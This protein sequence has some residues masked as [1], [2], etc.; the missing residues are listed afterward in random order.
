MNL[1]TRVEQVVSRYEGSQISN[2][3]IT[4]ELSRLGLSERGL[5]VLE[6]C[7]ASILFAAP[8]NAWNQESRNTPRGIAHPIY[9][10]VGRIL[11]DLASQ[12]GY[13]LQEQT[14]DG[15][16]R[17]DGFELFKN[18]VRADIFPSWVKVFRQCTPENQDELLDGIVSA[19]YKPIDLMA[20]R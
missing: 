4:A 7:D 16:Q 1:I 15:P 13:L 8:E 5:R 11:T 17:V 3:A 19:A 20:T 12:G 18:G 9:V 2:A 6:F 10:Q 14:E